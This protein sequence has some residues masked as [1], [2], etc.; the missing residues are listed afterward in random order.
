MASNLAI[1]KRAAELL[2]ADIPV[3]IATIIATKGSV[4]RY[5]GTKMLIPATGAPVGTIGG[6]IIEKTVIDLGREALSSHK[7]LVKSFETAEHTP[8]PDDIICGGTMTVVIEPEYPRDTLV[9]CGAGHVGLALYN[10]FQTLNFDMVVIDDRPEYAFTE[11]FPAAKK[12]ICSPFE[13]AMAE[14]HYGARSYVVIC[15]RRHLSDQ[16]CLEPILRSNAVYIGLLGSRTKWAQ[17]R[18]NLSG[19]G[20]SAEDIARVHCPVGLKIGAVTPEEIAVSIAAEI[21][22]HRTRVSSLTG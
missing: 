17:L 16:V 20:F 14:L 15:T 9:I 12:V 8:T 13:K 4:P 7:I 10:L 5:E 1:L 22:K 18:K 2:D 11:R 6:G 21:I 19:N 3:A